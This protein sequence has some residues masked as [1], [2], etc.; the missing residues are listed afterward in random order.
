MA[1]QPGIKGFHT[2]QATGIRGL[3]GLQNPSQLHKGFRL[4]EPTGI[5]EEE[6]EEANEHLDASDSSFLFKKFHGINFIAKL[7]TV[8]M[9]T[10]RGVISLSYARCY[11]HCVFDVQGLHISL[12]QS[13]KSISE[14]ME[15]KGE[16]LFLGWRSVTYWFRLQ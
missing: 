16:S 10:N 15:V 13:S 6:E 8:S 9:A 2:S 1:H 4:L 5:K 11:T 3:S 12:L 14:D 7:I